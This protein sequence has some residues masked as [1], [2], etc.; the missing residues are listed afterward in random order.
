[1]AIESSD[2][3]RAEVIDCAHAKGK[4]EWQEEKVKEIK[5]NR[6][7]KRKRR[8]RRREIYDGCISELTII[9]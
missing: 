7:R 4:R 6:K 1:L 3:V 8:R 9:C 5:E 2:S